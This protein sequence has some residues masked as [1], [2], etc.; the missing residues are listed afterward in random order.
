MHLEDWRFQKLITFIPETFIPYNSDLENLLGPGVSVY[1]SFSYSGWSGR[2]PTQTDK[3]C[4]PD[5]QKIL[6]TNCIVSELITC[7]SPTIWLSR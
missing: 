5:S 6:L 7:I 3:I 4:L 1:L 2:I